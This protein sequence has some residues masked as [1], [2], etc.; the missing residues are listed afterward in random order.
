MNDAEAKKLTLNVY[1]RWAAMRPD[2]ERIRR[3]APGFV[4]APD[5]PVMVVAYPRRYDNSF[6]RNPNYYYGRV[7]YGL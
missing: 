1:D 6:R 3:L 4:I 7:E 2:W 5:V